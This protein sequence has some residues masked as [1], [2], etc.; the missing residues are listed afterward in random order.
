MKK[1]LPDAEPADSPAL[2]FVRHLYTFGQ[3]ATDHSWQRLNAALFAAVEVAIDGGLEF[4]E[5]D[6][7]ALYDKFKG[8]HWLGT[9]PNGFY[10]A[11]CMCGNLSAARSF[12]SAMGF[13]PYILEGQRV[14]VG[15]RFAWNGQQ[16]RCTSIAKDGLIACSYK[17]RKKGEY[18]EKIDRRYT[19][20]NEEMAA[21]DKR[22]SGLAE[23]SKMEKARL[24]AVKHCADWHLPE[25]LQKTPVDDKMLARLEDYE[26]PRFVE[27]MKKR[28]KKTV[29]T[30]LECLT[31]SRRYPSDSYLVE[32]AVSR[33]KK[34]E[35]E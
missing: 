33:M 30:V 25:K 27:W 32:R 11:A 4:A 15:R 2:A 23:A 28:F 12:E 9:P 21:E 7:Q 24:A 17:D 8:A 31:M 20:T 18:A 1:K 19:I 34:E 3:Q 14:Y 6:F 5:G 26:R 22:L 10:S 13:K 16:V 29:P 35:A